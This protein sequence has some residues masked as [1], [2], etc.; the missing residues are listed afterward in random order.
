[1]AVAEIADSVHTRSMSDPTLSR[2]PT[3]PGTNGPVA[4]PTF[5][6]AGPVVG[7]EAELT[8]VRQELIAALTGRLAALAFEGEPGIGKTRLLVAAGEIAAEHGF[9]TVAATADEELAG[10]FLLARSFLGRAADQAAARGF[11][12]TDLR[13]GLDLVSGRDETELG[14][15]T[16]DQ[17]LLRVFDFTAVGIRSL[18]ATVPV[19]LL[20]DD[21]QWADEDSL[22]LLR[23]LVRTVVDVPL[24]IAVTV[25]PE[26]LADSEAAPL[27][28]DM[29]RIGVLRRLRLDRMGQADSAALLRQSLGGTVDLRSAAT[30]HAQSEGVPFMLQELACTYQGSGLVQQIDGVWTLTKHASRLVPSAVRSLIQRRSAHLPAEARTVL[31]EAAVLGRA[32]SLTDLVAVRER[33]EG[34]RPPSSA[35]ELADLLEAAVKA[36]LLI[37]L[38]ED[39]AADYRFAHEQVREL[40]AESLT[41]AARRALH[42]AVVDLLTGDGEPVPEMLPLLAQ[43]ALEA[44]DAPRAA[45]FAADAARAALTLRAPEEVLRLVER[46]LPVVATPADRVPL[47]RARDQAL[48]MLRRPT[49]RL[50]G[51]AEL[52]ALAEALND[53]HLELEVLLRRAAALRVADESEAAVRLADEARSRALDR[54]DRESEL[55]A[56]LELGQAHLDRPLGESYAPSSRDADLDRAQEAFEC[57][58]RLARDLGDEGVLAAVSREL[59]VIGNAR[60]RARYIELIRAGD[61]TP[62]V[63]RI[64]AGERVETMVEELGV[65][66]LVDLATAHLEEAIERFERLGDQRGLMSSVIAM[67]YMRFGADIHLHGSAKRIEEIRHLT[68]ELLSLTRESERD[69]TEAQMLYGVHVF[70]R[71][72][73]V[74]D[75]ALSRGEEAYRRAHLL[76]EHSLEFL[77][78]GGVAMVWLD[79][80]DVDAAE[81]WLDR[82]A[83][84]A[85]ASATSFKAR[86]LALWRG[87]CLAA[88]GDGAGMRRELERAIELATEQHRPAARCEALASLAQEAARL[89][90]ADQDAALLRL[91]ARAAD[92]VHMLVPSLPGHPL[93]GAQADAAKV[94]VALANGDATQAAQAARRALAA[95]TEANVEDVHPQIRIPIA[96]GLMAGGT[97]EEQRA[98]EQEVR[99]GLT[100]LAQRMHD[101]EVRVRWFR[102]PVG[103]ELI[104]L[105]GP[106]PEAVGDAPVSTLDLEDGRLVRLLVEGRT[107]R[108]MAEELGIDDD[109]L[110]RRLAEFYART[111]T[112]SRAQATSFAFRERVI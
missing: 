56:C 26:E 50:E 101:E 65:A 105:V 106:P 52:A 6:T 85:T 67:A 91:A 88:R 25:R 92:D 28:A 95:L 33:A 44:G 72:K 43:H 41:P 80:G 102:G 58:Y 69:R 1:V 32:F 100:L 17:G 9:L 81:A 66:P 4:L 10:P 103:R 48:E 19:A 70:A 75:L 83:L 108:Q 34:A 55:A 111:G 16:P 29:E 59:G 94:R 23:Y 84:S 5:R 22:R 21:L 61:I 73:I 109:A 79:L 104:D 112:G 98:V 20:L 49:D 99:T 47:L 62:Y 63:A 39:A 27:L 31:A 8:A 68:G 89:G 24:L 71:A 46:T 42:G 82:A 93:W 45:R 107:N 54:G 87:S 64:A 11:E 76:G 51:L 38:P 97:E 78:A 74:T 77:T 30:M 15:L 2:T 36:G 86:Q 53:A 18:A 110:V 14:A 96:L 40:T 7:R 57:A 60:L 3:R 90:A 37:V 35:S 13:R 12:A